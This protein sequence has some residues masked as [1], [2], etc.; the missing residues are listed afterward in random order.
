M[1]VI[2]VAPQILNDELTQFTIEWAYQLKT[3]L[4]NSEIIHLVP[5]IGTNASRETV[6]SYLQNDLGNKG[7]FIFID[8]GESDRL[9]DSNEKALIDHS[10]INL[11]ANKLIYT[12][13]CKSAL[14]LGNMAVEAGA[15][16][17]FGFEDLFQVVPEESNIFS[18]CF[19]YGATSII[20]D[21]ITPIEAIKQIIDKTSEIIVKIKKLHRLT[22][23]NRDILITG[24]RHNMNCMV[25]LGDPHWRLRPSNS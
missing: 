12:I 14:K 20:N 10:N 13:A 19:L 21:N 7:I 3:L 5:F 22:Q 25:Y 17:Y 9:Y 8:H 16:G 11:L 1:N 15:K 2:I 4:L 24:L 18:H 6:E 23:K